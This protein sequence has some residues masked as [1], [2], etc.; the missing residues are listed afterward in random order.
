MDAGGVGIV[1][2]RN[3]L[4]AERF[5]IPRLIIREGG[6]KRLSRYKIGAANPFAIMQFRGTL[7]GVKHAPLVGDF[8][9]R[10]LNPL[11]PFILKPDV[12]AQGVN[13]LAA[14]PPSELLPDFRI[15][16]RTSMACPHVSGIAALLKGAHLEWTAV[17]INSALMTT[18][19]TKDLDGNPLEDERY[20]T[21]TTVWAMG[22]GHVDPIKDL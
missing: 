6:R 18:T 7:L 13:T 16:L 19:Y 21:S 9:S 10:W 22:V 20:R 17:T 3:G 11:T 14:W 8:S 12:L 4:M 5:V 15:I 1:I 2:I